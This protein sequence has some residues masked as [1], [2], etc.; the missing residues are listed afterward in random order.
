MSFQ[1]G[2]SGLNASS[3][4]LDVIGNNIAN[5]GTYGAKGSRAEFA[6]VYAAA[7]NGAGQNQIGIGT[8]LSTV[9][10]QFT[11]GN[12]STTENPMDMAI[13][14]SGF[15]QLT[16]PDGTDLGYS[17]NGQFQLDKN[18]YV[19]NAGGLQLQGY[20]LDPTTR[21][22][23]GVIGPIQL[24]TQGIAP[25]TTATVDARLNLDARVP[26]PDATTPA[27]AIGN[28]ASYASSTSVPVFDAQGNEQVLTMYFRRTATDN[29]WEVYTGLNGQPVPA[30][31][32]GGSQLP[33]GRL[34]FNADGSLD[35]AASGSLAADGSFTAGPVTASLPFASATLGGATGVQVSL[36]FAGSTQWGTSFGLH[37][38]AQDGYAVGQLTGFDVTA[39]GTFEARYSN[40]KSVGAARIA[41]ANFRNPQGLT[42]GG[43]NMF[44]A[45]PASGQAAVGV[46]GS[47]DLGLLQ[48]GAL[49]ES[50]IDVTQ[51]LVAMIEAQRAYQASA[52]T[53]KTQ[54][55]VQSTV[56]NLR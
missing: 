25:R 21:R 30:P 43:N 40:G 24:P 19:V 50:N 28:T 12:I 48:G 36:G 42:P 44:R 41:L 56:V 47:A 29:Q 7:L 13:N 11:Q 5:S 20:A 1:Q 55:Q 39:D 16:R 45:T 26:A 34:S 52:Q 54:D 46:P 33:V 38:I 9:A 31:A 22:A 6:D 51:Q 27:F 3:K 49:E 8:T 18:G 17:R 35:A 14:G 10:Q 4:N 2:L 37:Q 53:I 15:F 23:S 32:G